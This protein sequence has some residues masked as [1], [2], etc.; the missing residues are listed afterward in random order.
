MSATN[1]VAS[2]QGCG[3]ATTGTFFEVRAPILKASKS[4]LCTKISLG[5]HASEE[6]GEHYGN[7]NRRLGY[8]VIKASHQVT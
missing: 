1:V 7:S 2:H 6:F 4:G 8:H 5:V 3:Q